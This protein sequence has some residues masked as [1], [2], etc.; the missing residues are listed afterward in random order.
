MKDTAIV[1][2]VGRG[3]AIDTEA[4][5][6]ALDAGK[7]GGVALDVTEPEP[8]P[9]AHTLY[10]RKNVIITPHMSGRTERYSQ[11]ALNILTTNLER[12]KSGKELLNIVDV[13]RGY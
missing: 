13:K 10:G 12:L 8:L 6:A 7:L 4:L 3:D 2:N 1:V 9:D 11:L 5:V